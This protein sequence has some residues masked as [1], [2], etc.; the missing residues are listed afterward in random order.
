MQGKID[1]ILSL[2]EQ[3]LGHSEAHQRMLK[4]SSNQEEQISYYSSTPTNASV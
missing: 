3:G 1:G 2:A 4:M